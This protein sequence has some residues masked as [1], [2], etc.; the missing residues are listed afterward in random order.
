M[1]FKSSLWLAFLF[2]CLLRRHF[3]LILPLIIF[4]SFSFSTGESIGNLLKTSTFKEFSLVVSSSSFWWVPSVLLL[5]SSSLLKKNGRSLRAHL[6]RW[7]SFCRM[8]CIALTF[9]GVT[10]ER[11]T[12]SPTA[13]SGISWML[14]CVGVVWAGGVDCRCCI[15]AA[16]TGGAAGVEHSEA[17]FS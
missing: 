13:T 12:S 17:A 8:A 15:G 6:C 2:I 16:G 5:L 4:H 3:E 14:D 7:V 9:R 1:F 11:I 10:Q